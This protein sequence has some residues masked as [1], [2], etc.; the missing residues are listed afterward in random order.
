MNKLMTLKEKYQKLILDDEYKISTESD[1]FS[2]GI[3]HE[4]NP[5]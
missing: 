4:V 3:I 1:S 2:G 5:R